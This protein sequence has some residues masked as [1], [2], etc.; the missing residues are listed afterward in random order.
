MANYNRLPDCTGKTFGR[1]FV[2]LDNMDGTVIGRCICGTQRQFYRSTLYSGATVSC[3]CF[4]IEKTI[5]RST[6]HGLRRHPMYTR[7]RSIIARCYYPS[8][9]SYA[10]YGAKGVTIY[11][12]WRE[13]FV[14]FL[15]GVGEPPS[16]LHT[17]DRYPDRHGNY[18]P[19]NVRWATPEEQAQNKDG[20]IRI[21]VDGSPL[22]I[23]ELS[24]RTR[25]TANR[26]RWRR[27]QGWPIERLLLPS[28]AAR[29]SRKT[30]V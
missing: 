26:L 11:A 5:E 21:V 14:A 9:R 2:V 6:T 20:T 3:G 17:L 8:V 25:I 27:S 7:W 12:P 16:P 1:V 29:L 19:G 28:G 22:T 10:D 24:L 23:N 30:L 13:S 4:C 18:E 15:E